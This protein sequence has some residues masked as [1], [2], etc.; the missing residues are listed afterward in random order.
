MV[1]R[2]V[3]SHKG[4]ALIQPSL[5][6]SIKLEYNP[7]WQMTSMILTKSNTNGVGQIRMMNKIQHQTIIIMF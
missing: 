5:Q 6:N 4:V 1:L 2:L 3:V 7:L